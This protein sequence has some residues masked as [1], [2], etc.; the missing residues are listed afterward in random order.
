M[1]CRPFY[2]KHKKK[3]M[4]MHDT[5]NLHNMTVVPEYCVSVE[6]SCRIKPKVDSLFPI[7]LSTS[8]DIGLDRV[9]LSG[10][11]PQELKVQLVTNGIRVGIHLQHNSVQTNEYQE[12]S[13]HTGKFSN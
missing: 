5:V 6:V 3:K 4:S 12:L 9:R 10:P 13:L 8:I 1:N 11:I 2:R 7:T